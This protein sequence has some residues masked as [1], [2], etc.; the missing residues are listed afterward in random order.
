MTRQPLADEKVASK[1]VF[2]RPPLL[3][4]IHVVI[5]AHG[6]R[7][8]IGKGIESG[9]SLK[10]AH[11]GREAGSCTFLFL[12]LCGCNQVGYSRRVDMVLV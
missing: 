1:E 10:G 9:P 11:C 5:S 2:E 4:V 12:I 6:M 3:C 8:G 7:E